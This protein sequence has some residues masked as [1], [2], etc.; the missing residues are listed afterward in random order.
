MRTKTGPQPITLAELRDFMHIDHEDDD[1]QLQR[2]IEAGVDYIER[3]TERDIIEGD[4]IEI[5]DPSMVAGGTCVT[6]RRSPTLSLES[7]DIDEVA[8]ASS[9]YTFRPNSHRRSRIVFKEAIPEGQ[10]IVVY[11]TGM[12]DDPTARQACLWAAAHFYSNREPEVVGVAV[13]QFKN[14]L[15]RMVKILGVGG[16]A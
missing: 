2:C 11:Q 15:D 9:D 8:V 14:G 16:Y 1:V 12:A 3:Q 10:M 5:V 7:V 6:L 4:V 13:S